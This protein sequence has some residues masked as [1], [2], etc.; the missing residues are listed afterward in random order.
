MAQ[1]IKLKNS[2]TQSDVPAIGDLILGEVAINTW[3]GKLFLKKND[4][5]EAIVEVGSDADTLLGQLPSYYLDYNNFSNTP[6]IPTTLSELTDD[7]THRLVTDT[8]KS[9]W[10]GKQDSLGFTAYD[11]TTNT[12]QTIDSNNLPALALTDVTVV[13]DTAARDGLTVQEGD[14][15]VVTDIGDGTSNTFIY[16]G[17]SWQTI[18][19]PTDLSTKS[20]TDLSEGTNLYFTDSRATTAVGGSVNDSGTGTTDIWSADKID[21][22]VSDAIQLGNAVNANVAP[23]ANDDGTSY[24]IGQVWVNKTDDSAYILV[25]D[26]ASSAIWLNVTDGGTIQSAS[27]VGTLGTGVFKQ[28]NGSDLEFRNIAS[29]TTADN[30]NVVLDGANNNINLSIKFNDAGTS[31]TDAWSANQISTRTIDGGSY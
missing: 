23:T 8:E 19:S 24:N 17:A 10:D 29:D 2:N 21:T 18:S 14:V 4:G 16:D 28:A 11:W 15:A 25:D 1:V 30:V 13:A 12:G 5:S 27:N 31:T 6:S 3:D 26:T 20:T 7:A 22:F 9:T